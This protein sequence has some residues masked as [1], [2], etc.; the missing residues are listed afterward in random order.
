MPELR[1][2][3][4]EDRPRVC[5]QVKP[6][7]T[8]DNGARG[9]SSRALILYKSLQKIH[10]PL[11]W[12]NVPRSVDEGNLHTSQRKDEIMSG[13]I[14]LFVVVFAIL[15]AIAPLG[16]WNRLI[17]IHRD[18]EKRAKELHDQLE[19]M[20]KMMSFMANELTKR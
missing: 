15:L 2:A 3:L 18:N 20:Q 9:I 4:S 5:R 6:R 7:R 10:G 8:A 19:K 14:A 11:L 13:G 17:K 12:Y 1:A 16:I